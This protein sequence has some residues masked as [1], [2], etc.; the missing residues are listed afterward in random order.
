MPGTQDAQIADYLWALWIGGGIGFLIGAAL[1][2]AARA[3]DRKNYIIQRAT[4]MPLALVNERDDVWLR[5]VSECDSPVTAPHFGFT[6]LHYD[7]KLEERVHRSRGSGKNRTTSSEWVTRETKTESAAFDLREGER[8]IAIDGAKADYKNLEAQS[9]HVGKWRHSVGYLPSPCA[10]SAV[11]SVSEKR[12][13]LE[14]YMNIP[15]MIT[16]KPREEFVKAAER[17]ETIMRFFG[18]LLLWAGAGAALY[19]LFDHTAWPAATGGRFHPKTLASG[20][21]AGTLVYILV[22]T[23]YIYNT[24]VTYNVRAANAWRQ[25]DVDLKMRYDL[26]PQLV[27]AVKGFMQ[28]EKD[29]LERL[30]QLR[31]EALSGGQK[32]EIATEGRMAGAV[33]ELRGVVEKYPDLKSQP[34][35]AKLMRELTAIEEKISHGRKTYNEAVSEYNANVLALP[36]GILARLTG[37]RTR[38]FF[39]ATGEDRKAVSV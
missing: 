19:G 25:I 8:T 13:R 36:R 39:Q 14:P 30:V 22:W 10:I 37:F 32:T 20:V 23:V 38:N 16:P 12:A 15:L 34:L 24:F 11:G 21:G 7:Y 35:A 5:G 17:A 26:V 29:L 3:A 31:G 4:P 33:T 18:F 1:L 28:H 2:A 27:G 6:C 9:E